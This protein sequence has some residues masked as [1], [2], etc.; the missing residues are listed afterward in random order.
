VLKTTA[1]TAV[2]AT[3]NIGSLFHELNR[4]K[5][6]NNTVYLEFE[7]YLKTGGIVDLRISTNEDVSKGMSLLD[8]GIENHY[9]LFECINYS[10][11]L[12]TDN[13][14]VL[15]NHKIMTYNALVKH[16]NMVEHHRSVDC[17]IYDE[18]EYEEKLFKYF[19][20]MLKHCID[21]HMS[22]SAFNTFAEGVYKFWKIVDHVVFTRKVNT[23][24]NGLKGYRGNSD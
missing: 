18:K 20:I 14:K 13:P 2:P 22:H 15:R 16:L 11:L 6:T 17:I 1:S 3:I 10:R 12:K 23:E 7:K 8:I 21:V 9:V 5:E 19:P 4:L 24:L